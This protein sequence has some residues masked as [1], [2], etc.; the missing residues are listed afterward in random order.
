MHEAVLD[1]RHSHALPRDPRALSLAVLEL[2]RRSDRNRARALARARGL[3][4][5]PVAGRAAH[6]IR[7]LSVRPHRP[8]LAPAGGARRLVLV[9]R[10]CADAAAVRRGH[11]ESERSLRGPARQCEPRSRIDSEQPATRSSRRLGAAGDSEQ[12]ATRSSPRPDDPGRAPVS[13]DCACLPRTLPHFAGPAAAVGLQ[14]RCTDRR[15]SAC[16]RPN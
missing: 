1:P 9:S 10:R 16:S 15:R 3:G 8:T 13:R 5:R 7:P 14:C 11:S 12:P 2:A 6:H 4:R